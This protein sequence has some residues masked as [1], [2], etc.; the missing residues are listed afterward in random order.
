MITPSLFDEPAPPEP[1]ID[2]ALPDWH[3][4]PQALFLSWS[5]AMQMAYCYRRDA[6]S[7]LRA[8]NNTDAA[9]YLERAAQYKAAIHA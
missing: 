8:D 7:A 3:E 6:D 2:D 1:E 9:F 4:V 5:D